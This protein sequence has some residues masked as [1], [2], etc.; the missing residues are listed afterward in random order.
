MFVFLICLTPPH[1]FF[2]VALWYQNQ[3]TSSQH[4][5]QLNDLSQE[6]AEKLHFARGP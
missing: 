6:A 3:A 4:A 1:L 2:P 5:Q